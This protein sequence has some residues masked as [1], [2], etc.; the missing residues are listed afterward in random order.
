VLVLDPDEVAGGSLAR[1]LRAG[2]AQVTWLQRAVPAL[3]AA[4]SGRFAAAVIV[5][6]IG[7]ADL[8]AVCAAL[9]EGSAPPALVLLDRNGQAAEVERVLPGG[10]RPDA[11]LPWP[12]EPEKLRAELE[13]VLRRGAAAPEA[14]DGHPLFPELLVELSE[15]RES[16]VLEVRAG[17]VCTRLYLNE[18]APAFAE[19]GALRE[20][21]GRML[22]RRG[23]IGEDEYLRVIERMT[24]RLIENETTRMGEV[25]VELGILGP[26][27]V[28]EALS[29]QVRE[30]I[31]ACFQWERFEHSFEPLDALPPDVLA[32]DCPPVE[33]LVLGGLRAH[34]GA[35]RVEPILAPHADHHPWLQGEPDRIAARFQ[36]TPTERRLLRQLGGDR[37]LAAI[38]AGSPL[39]DLRTGQLIAALWLGRALG[40]SALPVRPAAARTRGGGASHAFHRPE[41]LAG[42]IPVTAH[43]MRSLVQLRGQLER[44]Q[45]AVGSSDAGAEAKAARLDAERAFRQGVRLLGQGLVHGALRELAKAAA[46]MGDEPEYRMLHAW[47]EY[48]AARDDAARALARS[49]AEASAQRMLEGDRRSARA[50][51]I[52]GQL[53][54]AAGSLELAGHHFRRALQIDANEHD[55][56]RGL[57]LIERRRPSRV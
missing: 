26:R 53:A 54:Q 41:A 6:P 13:G 15:R 9:K 51:S 43:R 5:S 45:R 7:D 1:G 14:S 39:D 21:L 23:A 57:R 25:L 36:M 56:L 30:K 10:R 4:R 20:T 46:R 2:G 18:G 35:E 32:Y 31:A 12:I 49:K 37:S 42:R 22:L 55:A 28:F 52:L 8:V 50:H 29:A 38:R 33:A 44:A 24:E 34:F 47:A 11:V 3:E 19:G 17:G 27:D 40:F 16:G 48:L